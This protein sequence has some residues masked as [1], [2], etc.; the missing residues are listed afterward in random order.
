VILKCSIGL[1]FFRTTY[2]RRR[3]DSGEPASLVNTS[4]YLRILEIIGLVVPV[5]ARSR[6]YLL[7]S[8]HICTFCAIFEPDA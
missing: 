5:Q 2:A 6:R 3:V 1:F 8:H 4:H 7:H